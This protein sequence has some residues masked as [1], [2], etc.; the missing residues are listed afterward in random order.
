MKLWT[1]KRCGHTGLT[2]YLDGWCDQCPIIPGCQ[3]AHPTSE[4]ELNR[5]I[6]RESERQ[7]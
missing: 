5:M 1:C 7:Q 2:H 3:S 4:D 6:K